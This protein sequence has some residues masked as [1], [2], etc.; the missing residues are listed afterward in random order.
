MRG[1]WVFGLR[2]WLSL[3][4]MGNAF[5]LP[6]SGSGV[7]GPRG[8][9][10]PVPVALFGV[11]LLGL[12][13]REHRQCRRDP[14]RA[15]RAEVEKLLRGRG[16]GTWLT[17]AGD[18]LQAR[19]GHLPFPSWTVSRPAAYIDRT[20]RAASATETFTFSWYDTKVLRTLAADKDE[21][22]READRYA[23]RGELADLAAQVRDGA[24]VAAGETLG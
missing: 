6:V 14:G 19:R 11:L 9:L 20:G 3:C 7:F 15:A 8:I 5:I 24:L 16:S 1:T 13:V 12:T 4:M 10:G 2:Y 17:A 18:T 22:K 23:D 21:G